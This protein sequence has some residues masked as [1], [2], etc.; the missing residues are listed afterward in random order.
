MKQK[1]ST[2]DVAAE[3]ACLQQRIVNMRVVN[4]YDINPKARCRP[5]CR[6]IAAVHPVTEVLFVVV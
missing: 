4:V 2:A 5:C 1:M 6:R 3:V